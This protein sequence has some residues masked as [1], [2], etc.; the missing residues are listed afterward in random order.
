MLGGVLH[1]AS[2]IIEPAVASGVEAARRQTFSALSST[3]QGFRIGRV[4]IEG[5]VKNWGGVRC[6]WP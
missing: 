3:T 2:M 6:L 4:R 5:R 1:L